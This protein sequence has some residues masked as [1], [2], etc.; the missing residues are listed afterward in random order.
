MAEIVEKPEP[1]TARQV[2]RRVF[3][4]ENAVL[5]IV[6]IALIAGMAGITKGLTLSRANM[7]NVLLQSSIRGVASVGQAFVILSAGIDLSVGGIGL[8][9][10]V[11]GA[12][13]MT[14]DLGLNIVGHPLSLFL[15]IPIMLLVGVGWGA[16]NGSLVSRVGLPALIVTL[17]MWQISKGAAFEVSGGKYIMELPDSLAFFGEGSVA[18]VPVPVIIFIVVA[19]V[20]YFVLSYTTFGRSIYAVGCNP[21]SA[22]LTGINVKNMLFS[23]Y[24][25]AGFLAGLAG[26]M[27]TA[28][29]MSAAMKTLGGL[30]LETIAAVCVGGVSIMGGRG[31]LI[32]VVIGALIIGIINNGMTVLGATLTAQS[33][34]KGAIII[35]AVAIDY[36]RRR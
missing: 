1:S 27:I 14:G 23:V 24:G 36:I 34:A 29:T 32:G 20:A 11:L 21:V 13:M 16:I 2:A 6:L 28:R 17:G 25:I 35:T 3:R 12:S 8:F 15:V 18:G 31:S 33:I 9:T 30:E 7:S 19:V 10:A 5:I 26:I 22:W 4:H